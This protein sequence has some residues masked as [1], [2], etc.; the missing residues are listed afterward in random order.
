MLHCEKN[1]WLFF[2]DTIAGNIANNCKRLVRNILFSYFALVKRLIAISFL[3]VF[4]SANTAFGEL[5]K[6]PILIHHFWEHRQAASN[7]TIID[8][9]CEHYS[10]TIQHDDD[11]HH[12]H[13]KLPFKSADCHFAQVVITVPE[14]RFLIEKKIFFI[15]TIKQPI[16]NIEPHANEYLHLIWQPP[17]LG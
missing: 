6:L 13:E 15:P 1:Q 5:L 7:E 11:K 3:L 4:I 8:F 9:L 17:R 14:Q 16:Y 10:D 2:Y 12:D